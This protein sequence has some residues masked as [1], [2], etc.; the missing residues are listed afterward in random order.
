MNQYAPLARILLRYL[1][2]ISLGGAPIIGPALAVDPDM[3]KITAAVI[4]GSVEGFY[5]LAKKYGGAT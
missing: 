3:V 2:G 4:G 5:Y 1:A